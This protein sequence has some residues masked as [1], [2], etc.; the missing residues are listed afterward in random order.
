M[1][2]L[3]HSR[4]DMSPSLS[5]KNGMDSGVGDSVSIPNLGKGKSL[6]P[7]PVPPERSNFLHVAIG[8]FGFKIPRPLYFFR[9]SSCPDTDVP[10]FPTSSRSPRVRD[11]LFLGNV[12]KIFKRVIEAIKVPVV[13]NMAF[14]RRTNKTSDDYS[15][16]KE[17]SL[18]RFIVEHYPR[19]SAFFAQNRGKYSSLF[20]STIRRFASYSS[21][22]RDGVVSPPSH[23]N[24]FFYSFT[25][26]NG[27][28]SDAT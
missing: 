27:L 8:K 14:W 21:K 10:L 22:V 16:N 23:R 28:Y 13:N 26:L 25:H 12:L 4:L 9:V 6:Y 1:K 2:I 11:I 3:V 19:V 15:V 24:P 20:I 7:K 17:K 5:G 18:F